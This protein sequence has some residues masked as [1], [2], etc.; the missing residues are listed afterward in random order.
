MKLTDI[1][2]GLRVRVHGA[3]GGPDNRT[4]FALGVVLAPPQK[5]SNRKYAVRVRL[6]AGARECLVT[7]SRVEKVVT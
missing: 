4:G 3:A 2:E 7:I 6:D 1:T 5:Q